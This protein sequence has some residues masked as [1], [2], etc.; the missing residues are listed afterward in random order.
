MGLR[1]WQP[2]DADALAAAWADPDI[3]RWTAV[4]E[5]R[6]VDAAARWIAGWDE[7]R[8]RGLALDLVVTPADDAG[9][10][11]GEV[12]VAFVTDPPT[13]GW[14]VVPAVRGRGVAT[15]AVR[16]FVEEFLAVDEVVAEVDE[17]NPAS[18]AVARAAGFETV[19]HGRM[20]NRY[21]RRRP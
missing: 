13:M 2:T 4:P 1:A 6:S 9:V 21:H 10:V 8:R 7:R 11:W 14:W 19:T 15:A 5:D 12:G 17:A 18:V 3:A 20:V 16:R